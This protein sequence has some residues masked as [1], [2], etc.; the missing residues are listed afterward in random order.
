MK[1]WLLRRTIITLWAHN[2]GGVDHPRISQ[3]R[4]LN[5]LIEKSSEFSEVC[6]RRKREDSEYSKTLFEQKAGK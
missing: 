2:S 6:G 3:L 1:K 4:N 5:I